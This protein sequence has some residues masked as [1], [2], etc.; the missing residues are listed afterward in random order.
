LISCLQ[1]ANIFLT[2]WKYVCTRINYTSE[3]QLSISEFKTPFE[4]ALLP[5]NRWVVFSCQVPWD[6]FASITISMMNRNIGRPGLCPLMVL[7]ALIIKHQENLDDSRVIAA[8]QENVCMQFFVGLKEFS[9]KPIFDPSLFV[10]IRKR[11]GA[12]TFDVLNKK[13]IQS[14]SK[15][16]DEK[17]NSK[18]I[19]IY[20]QTKGIFKWMLQLLTNTLPIS[21]IVNC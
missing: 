10:E 4:M 17:Q 12:N 15:E 1:K 21:P 14:I 16:E 11:V 6:A 19:M 9:T 20:Y 8:I 5:T 7:G 18:K 2:L 3:N 13:L